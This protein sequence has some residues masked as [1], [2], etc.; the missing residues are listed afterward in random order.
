MLHRHVVVGN[1]Q[2]GKLILLAGKKGVELGTQRILDPE[3][4]DSRKPR[5]N[6]KS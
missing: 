3:S 6:P 5:L 4:Q 1:G 2:D